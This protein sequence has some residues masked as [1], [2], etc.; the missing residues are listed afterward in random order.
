M[1]ATAIVDD[2]R[3]HAEELCALLLAGPHG[4]ELSV[5]LYDSAE[6]FERAM[7]KRPPDL[8]F[9][10]IVLDDADPAPSVD[11]DRGAPPAVQDPSGRCGDVL[12]AQGLDVVCADAVQGA[13]GVD[14][15]AAYW[16]PC[17][18]SACASSSGIDEVERLV[19]GAGTQVIYMSAYDVYHTQVYRTPHVCYLRKPLRKDDVEVALDLALRRLALQADRPLR[20]QTRGAQRVVRPQEILYLESDLRLVRVH[21]RGEAVE[22][23]GKLSD[24]A[25]LLPDRFVRCHQ[26]FLVNLDYVASLDAATLRLTDGSELPV[27][28]R[29]RAAVR[30]ALFA[31]VRSGC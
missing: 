24:L 23:Y 27:S 1:Y 14:D 29:H 19:L 25:R 5:G 22:A 30:D 7:Q 31:H 4:S 26:S 28:R 8:L 3:Q 6:A 11:V 18:D 17:L 2:N 20:F 16:S 9:M 15:E 13:D 21:L 10:D 12:A